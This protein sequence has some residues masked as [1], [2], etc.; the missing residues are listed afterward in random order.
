[1]KRELSME[2]L[3]SATGNAPK[4]ASPEPEDAHTCPPILR[5]AEYIRLAL[6]SV[7]DGQEASAL[8]RAVSVDIVDD[9]EIALFTDVLEELE[10]LGSVEHTVWGWRRREMRE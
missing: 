5:P 1:M 6:L 4:P 3:I 10:K 8:D 2:A 7:S 9:W